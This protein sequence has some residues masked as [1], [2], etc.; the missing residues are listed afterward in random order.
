MVA[1]LKIVP[2]LPKLKIDPE[3]QRL[4]PPLTPEAR[5]QLKEN[6]L[7]GDITPEIIVWKDQDIIIDGHHRYEICQQEDIEFN[8]LRLKFS[9]RSSV[10]KWMIKNQL[11]RRNLPPNLVSYFRGLI[12]N[13][14]KGGDDQQVKGQNVP[15]TPT[16]AKTNTAEKLAAEHG[17]SAKTIKRDGKYAESVN[18]IAD[19][20]GI[21]P[22]AVTKNLTKKEVIE[23]ESQLPDL[24]P[25]EA[26][27]KASRIELRDKKRKN[28]AVGS[29]AMVKKDSEHPALVGHK[30]S[31]VRITEAGEFGATIQRGEQIIPDISYQFLLPVENKVYLKIDPI[32][33][34]ELLTK[35]SCLSDGVEDL[36][37]QWSKKN[38]DIVNSK[39]P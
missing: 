8:V 38:E 30:G 4:L 3:F 20:A 13:E 10:K 17:V 33:C 9:D 2:S 28:P 35:Y 26:R 21:A 16:R 18:A 6:L 23:L 29:L 14:Q 36:I 24:H 25:Y 12:Y 32:L 34:A 1:Q 22:S 19:K 39:N 7:T 11:G 27:T 5:S 15:L 31:H 37:K